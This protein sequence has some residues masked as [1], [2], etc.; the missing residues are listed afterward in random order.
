MVECGVLAVGFLVLIFFHFFEIYLCRSLLKLVRSIYEFVDQDGLEDVPR[1]Q[2][3]TGVLPHSTSLR[4]RM[5]DVNAVPQDA[6]DGGSKQM[7]GLDGLG[8]SALIGGG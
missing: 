3:N 7:P 4:V 2:R 1:Q 5:T 8:F 6:L